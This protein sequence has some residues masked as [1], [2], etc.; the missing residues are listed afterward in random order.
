MW[1]LECDGDLFAGK[2][3]WLRPGRSL[4][5]GRTGHS[6]SPTERS[7]R[8]DFRGVSRKH[9]IIAVAPSRPGDSYRVNAK[10]QLTIT[11]ESK[12]GTYLDGTKFT[13]TSKILYNAE[14]S[15]Q[16][17]SYQ[18]RFKITWRPTVLTFTH[19]DKQMRTNALEPYREKLEAF[20]IKVI[21]DYLVDRT[22]H[23]VAS[24]RNLPKVLQ[25]LVNARHVVTEDFINALVGGATS[26]GLTGDDM[27]PL[28]SPFEMDFEDAW[29]DAM[30]YVPPSAKEPNPRPPEFF[31]PDA[32]RNN[33]FDGFTFVFSDTNQYANLE[34]PVALAGAKCLQYDI[35][36]GKTSIQEFTAY[37]RDLAGKKGSRLHSDAEL[38]GVVV[39]RFRS[40]FPDTEQWAIDFLRGVDLELEQRSIEQNE[41]L[42]AILNRDPGA[43]RKALLEEETE[44][45]T[46][47]PS[48]AVTNK[49]VSQARPPSARSAQQSLQPPPL[50]ALQAEVS[51]EANEQARTEAPAK[52]APSWKNRRQVTQ[53]RFKGFDDFDPS[54]IAKRSRSPEASPIDEEDDQGAAAP[55]S[56]PQK[57]SNGSQS[58]FVDDDDEPSGNQARGSTSR[59]RPRPS[60]QEDMDPDARVDDLLPATRALKKRKLERDRNRSRDASASAFVAPDE[61]PPPTEEPK[62][63][64][65]KKTAAN[66]D[67]RNATRS[68]AEAMD[69]KANPAARRKQAL[70]QAQ[71]DDD[72][73]ELQPIED[74]DEMRSLAIVETMEVPARRGPPARPTQ[75]SE[76]AHPRTNRRT[77]ATTTGNDATQ[78]A[79]NSNARETC[80]ASWNGRKNFKRF[81]R[82]GEAIPNR[83]TRVIV[84]LELVR[85][86]NFGIGDE[87][88]LDDASSGKKSRDSGGRTQSQSQH[89]APGVEESVV[90]L[91]EDD[92]V[93]DEESLGRVA[94]VAGFVAGGRDGN[95]GTKR[96]AAADGDSQATAKR[97]R[98]GTTS[99]APTQGQA[100][101]KARVNLRQ[102]KE[103]SS[104]EED[105][106]KFRLR[107]R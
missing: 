107:R 92:R 68:N 48:T 105:E 59:K 75:R 30:K 3:I 38:K 78:S 94:G 96:A 18:Q 6:G 4:L 101:G 51:R 21:N 22:T 77:G 37:V 81:R 36:L 72:P 97:A 80:N 87:Y 61:P 23:V 62:T 76:K 35:E 46:A 28:A 71:E 47:P 104:S 53:S 88:W 10:S 2:K 15:I 89:V 24:K 31:A 8:I 103:E 33:I 100:R 74:I 60:T 57:R 56:Q 52:P 41:F 45:I 70:A 32:A 13:G 1:I 85:Q 19:T 42:D 93:E 44:G 90:D 39:V 106:L 99:Q 66:A 9:L 49:A 12:V 25:A 83:S 69:R 73:D 54:Q 16:L 55:T 14:H 20:D 50:S 40:K 34:P 79:D 58:L 82:K 7:Y 86:K 67:I 63:K 102:A 17:G 5:L 29:P 95:G 84:P 91:D 26:P 65:R 64:G 98:Q 27:L 43:L 11:D